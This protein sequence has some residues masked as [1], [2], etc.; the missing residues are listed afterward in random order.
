MCVLVS[1]DPG[2]PTLGT[3]GD[4]CLPDGSCVSPLLICVRAKEYLVLPVDVDRC[5]PIAKA[6]K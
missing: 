3:I 4:A 5:K 6:E 1:C 2:K